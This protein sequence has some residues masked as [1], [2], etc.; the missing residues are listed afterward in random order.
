MN[1]IGDWGIASYPIIP[2]DAP[3]VAYIKIIAG[4]T[5]TYQI[6][7]DGFIPVALFLSM[8]WRPERGFWMTHAMGTNITPPADLPRT[9]PGLAPRAITA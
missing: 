4:V 7:S 6:K 1:A 8:V 9:S 5:E 3:D 2:A